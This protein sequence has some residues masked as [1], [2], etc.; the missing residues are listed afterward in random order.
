MMSVMKPM[1]DADEHR[2]LV[3]AEGRGA[4]R[5]S[6]RD[7]PRA[8][9]LDSGA[10]PPRENVLATAEPHVERRHRLQGVFLNK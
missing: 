9:A 10:E 1:P 5:R 7:D 8:F 6:Y 4:V 3:L 2:R